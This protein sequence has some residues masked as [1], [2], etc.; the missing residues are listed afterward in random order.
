MRRGDVRRANGSVAIKI[1]DPLLPHRHGV[2]PPLPEY[3][4]VGTC[5]AEV[6]ATSAQAV[7]A[8][9]DPH[10]LDPD[11][12]EVTS[13]TG[14]MYRNWERQY[15]WIDTP[16]SQVLYGFLGHNRPLGTSDV[17]VDVTSDFAVIALSSLTDAPLRESDN[18]LLTTVGRARNSGERRESLQVIDIGTTPIMTQVIEA[19]ISI[20]TS[21]ANLKV[22]AVNA[23]GFY[24]G[25]LATSYEDGLLTFRIGDYHP[26]IYYLI[27]T[28]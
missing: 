6:P 10:T 7:I 20:R 28:E 27:R 2:Y 11:K 15:G 14:E 24:I 18:I 16:R 1:D 22:W 26:S 5:Y 12:K 3:T 23:E 4:R 25:S 21:Q 17:T 8:P 19:Q 9:M 13:D